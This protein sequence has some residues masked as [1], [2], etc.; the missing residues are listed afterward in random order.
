VVP[1]QDKR[2]T[3]EEWR[4]SGNEL[5]AQLPF[6]QLPVLQVEGKYLAQSAA[7]DHYAAKLGGLLPED[8]WQAAL[9][10]QAYFFCE[11]VWQTM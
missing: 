10:D 6:G 7:I 4:A 3:F 8:A 9:A 1:L 5:K 11:D 2:V